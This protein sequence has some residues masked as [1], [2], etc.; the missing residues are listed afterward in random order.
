MSVDPASPGK[1]A[2]V[3]PERPALL[4]RARSRGRAAARL[5]DLPRVPDVRELLR[6]VP[7]PLRAHRPRH[8][9]GAAE[10]AETLDDA[11]LQRR[12]RPLLAVQALLHQVPVHAGRGRHELLDFPRLMAREK[13]QRAQRDGHP[14]RGPDPRRAAARSAS[15]ASGCRAAR[16]PR[17]REPAPPQGEREGH[18]HLGRVPA[19][20]RSPRRRS[21]L[22]RT[23]H[24]PLPTRRRARRGRALRDLPRRLQHP[25]RRRARR[26]ACSSRTAS[27]VV[28]GR[29]RRDR[30]AQCCG[31]PNLD[32]GDIDAASAKS[33]LQRRAALPHVARRPHV[34]VPGPRAGTR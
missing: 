8:R 7:G 31:M 27:R 24:T 14:A 19:A 17:Q 29:G 5:R 26:C 15:S 22:A 30:E 25:R 34:V 2:G 28:P 20:R 10:G 23:T 1:P 13:A 32:G 33:A 16:E 6:L 3:Q 9:A 12:H 11:R 21:Q 18:R 4:G